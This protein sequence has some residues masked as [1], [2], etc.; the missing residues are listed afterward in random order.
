[1]SDDIV[2]RLRAWADRLN[3][4]VLIL[5]EAADEIERLRRLLHEQ[6]EYSLKLQNEFERLRG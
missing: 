2:T 3:P 4:S 5:A 1:M 6:N